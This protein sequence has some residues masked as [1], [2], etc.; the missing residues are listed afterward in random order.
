MILDAVSTIE[1]VALVGRLAAAVMALNE[2]TAPLDRIQATKTVSDILALLGDSPAVPADMPVDAAAEELSDDPNSPNYR[3]RDTGYIAG[4]RK[5]LAANTIRLARAAGQRVLATD[6]DW[7]EVERNPRAAAQLITKSN[8]FGQTDWDR[9]EEGGMEGAAGFLIDRVYASIGTQPTENTPLDRHD[10]ALALETIRNR[11]ESVKTVKEVVDVLEDIRDELMGSQLNADETVR[12]QALV[13]QIGDLQEQRSAL[14]KEN[15][16]LADAANA[17][18]R[19]IGDIEWQQ[20]KRTNRKWQR[21]PD[22]DTQIAALTPEREARFAEW[23]AWRDAHP[24]VEEKY[25]TVRDENGITGRL[26]GGLLG[27][28]QQLTYQ[29]SDIVTEARKRNLAESPITRGWLTFGLKFFKVLNYR[30]SRNGSESFASHFTNA[31][32]GKIPDWSWAKKEKTVVKQATKQEI[33]FQLKVA[34]TMERIGGAP[35]KVSSTKDLEV[36][37]GFSAVQS[38]NWVL[39]DPNSAK[40]HVEQTAAA[41]V[42]MSD[43]L[44][45]KPEY[46]GLGGRLGMAFG[47]RG[48]GN[49][50]GSTAKATYEPVQRVINLTKM[51]GG[52]SLGHEWFHA[53]DNVLG[54]L[55]TGQAAAAG[56]YGS[57]DLTAVPDG[58]IRD[59]IFALKDAVMTG[60]HRLTETIKIGPKD[61]KLA[62]YNINAGMPNAVAKAIKAAGEISKAVLAVDQYFSGR[63]DKRS[64]KNRKSWRTLA[65]AYYSP[66]GATEAE[67]PTGP[68]VSSF[69]YEAVILDNGREGKYWSKPNELFARAFQ[70]YLEDTLA[71]QE[72]KNDYLS[73][74]ADNKY[75]YDAFLGIQWNPYPDGDERAK[76]NAGFAQ[77]FSAIREQQ[78]FEKAT[79]NKALL[80]AIF[81]EQQMDIEIEQMDIE[82]A[83]DA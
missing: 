62:E 67:V 72:R 24:E 75:H 53:V 12:Y 50:G 30:S 18:S 55:A 14:R 36:M 56:S 58:P 70:S 34:D 22:M 40:F 49:A 52:G 83:A 44:G 76:L 57:M 39:K 78:V 28:I 33:G 82:E 65:A 2:A 9:L 42:D 37:M 68:G 3:Y 54:E 13:T 25:E 1:R 4:S 19:Q 5:E 61:K 7:A 35:V 48:T 77:L 60:E 63:D 81:G 6:L 79:N 27:Q 43:I 46:L 21:D 47:A 32:T 59:A 26:A 80:D 51:G 23:Q 31:A 10:Y 8:L 29:R 11:L 71:A 41:M 66:E 64:I 38:G 17:L 45:I 20:Q 74:Y 69:M 15:D 73:S 16:A